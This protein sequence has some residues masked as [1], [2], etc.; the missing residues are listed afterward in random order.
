LLIFENSIKYNIYKFI[1]YKIVN[2]YISD[3]IKKVTDIVLK[4]IKNEISVEVINCLL[5]TRIF[6]RLNNLNKAIAN[7]I[8]DVKRTKVNK[9]IC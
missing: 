9:F 1:K 7:K 2:T 3:I 4:E 6:I 5:R 8:F